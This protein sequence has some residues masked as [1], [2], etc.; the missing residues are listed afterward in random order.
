LCSDF[1]GSV[2][3]IAFDLVFLLARIGVL[4]GG[5]AFMG[6]F[7]AGVVAAFTTAF[8]AGA[9]FRKPAGEGNTG[10][11]TSAKCIAVH[12]SFGVLE[13]GERLEGSVMHSKRNPGAQL[14]VARAEGRV[15]QC[16]WLPGKMAPGHRVIDGSSGS[17]HGALSETATVNASV[18]K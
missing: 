16:R 5:L 11:Y 4:E 17:Y 10:G 14:V 3:F 1:T 6:I 15:V 18:L 12:R 2:A 8:T 13:N 9:I 7:A